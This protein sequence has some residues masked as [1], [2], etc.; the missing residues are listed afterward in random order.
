MRFPASRL[1]GLVG[2]AVGDAALLAALA[3]PL[4]AWT[5]EP[6]WLVRDWQ[7]EDG[8]PDANVTAIQ[9]TPDGYL[10]V[11]TP[12]GLARFDGAQFKVF[13]T[14][15]VPVLAEQ[16][17]S[18][19]LADH[20]G[21]LW[22]GCESGLLL[23]Y[24]HGRFQP[25]SLPTGRPGL[26]PAAGFVQEREAES[27]ATTR[28]MW[29]RPTQFAEDEAGG[30]WSI[31]DGG[32]LL[33]CYGGGPTLYTQ[34]NGLP[35]GELGG[36][37][38]DTAGQ[39]WLAAGNTLF[40]WRGGAWAASQNAAPLG[41]PLGCLAAAR[42]GG[43]WAAEPRGSWLKA[44][45]LVR[46]CE[47]GQWRERLEPTPWIPNSLRSQVTTLLEDHVGR[48]WIGMLW[49]GIW[50]SEAGLP[51][52]RLQS[53]GPLS[54]CIITCLYEDREGAVW[55]GT[56][57]EGLH[58]IS[59]RPVTMLKLPAP[60]QE[61]IITTSCAARDGSLWAGTD[62]AGAFR[63]SD[64][65]FLAFDSEQGLSDHHVCSILE[66]S[67]TN[68]WFGTW[69]GLFHFEQGRFTRVEGPPELGLAVLA[70]FEDHIGRLWVG[71]PRGLVCRR[72]R[73]WSVHRLLAGDAFLDIRSFAED[74][75]GN[76]WVGTIG[77]GLFR[78]REDQ[79]I[80]FRH[81]EGFTSQNARSLYCDPAGVLW[82]G[83]DGAGLFR[84]QGG[85]FTA[86]TS[87]DGLPCDTIS[88]IL[89]DP[90]GRLWMSSDNGIF[91]CSAAALQHY[92]RGHSP[93][94]LCVRLTP[95][96]GLGSRNCSGSG[97]PVPSH[98]AD[99]RFWFPNMRGLA[100][101]DPRTLARAQ[102]PSPRVL[103]ESVVV[104]RTELA[105]MA[106]GQVHVRSSARRFEFRYTVP[107]LDA[108]QPLRFRYKL[109]G[110]DRDWTDAKSE[111]AASYSQLP[112]GR[113]QFRVMAGGADGEWHETA[114][115]LLLYVMPRP[116]EL[117]WVQVL[118]GMLLVAAVAASIRL[119]ERRRLRRRLERL[120]M[121]Q[122]LETE[123]RRIARD[124]HDDLGASLTEIVLLG[125]L[126]RDPSQPP[127]ALQA[128]VVSIMQKIRQFVA[129]LDET[130]WTINP[131]NDSLPSLADF[132]A[133][134]AERFLTPTGIGCRLEVAEQ[135]PPVPVPASVRHHVLL[136]VKEALNNAVRHAAARTVWLRLR[137]RA[138][139][140]AIA[141][142][143]DGRGLELRSAGQGGDGLQ[144]MRSRM[145]A[146]H[147]TVQFESQP[148]G[149]TTVTFLL[150]LASDV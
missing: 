4:R 26:M 47:A 57:G 149:G 128:Q 37:C 1:L 133:D 90:A 101:F 112:P 132:L 75:E 96:E 15:R 109:D 95:A 93:A 53:E 24:E 102:P 131:K 22:I 69:G 138:G 64:G 125:E 91:A 43:I 140:L 104:D 65:H 122:A 108:A 8:L 55:V 115:P 142:A 73:E 56:V 70:L 35:P 77:Q 76:L 148:G 83:S 143:D 146:V 98:S 23:R 129:A 120:E 49:N 94:L 30:V 62:G 134:Y 117:R 17:I 45:G 3:A 78:L 28:W 105:S 81:R 89:P 87:A 82:V 59:Q 100:V 85:Q 113:Y 20:R 99:G 36:L 136:A 40:S 29:G 103:V 13:D 18:A 144:N 52:R 84:L 2:R 80:Q 139:Q 38:A 61:S 126:A 58:R 127:G 110:M 9:Q 6:E 141:I 121:Q 54:Q 10:W 14:R 107:D 67:H 51:W 44:G 114:T 34:T 119:N 147:G 97:Q 42:Q 7:T 12:K 145:E 41:G 116:W 19:L 48:V 130:V 33:R 60:A 111:R 72:E 50:F 5:A 39:L 92:H 63:Y 31:L 135:L 16:R 124:L 106:G 118:A 46:R 74:P 27:G 79:V 25:V 71:T 123:R 137:L 32:S 150:P 21:A 86:Y 66:D 11:G 88:S 68:L